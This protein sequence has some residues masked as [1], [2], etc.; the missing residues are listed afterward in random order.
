MAQAD[1]VQFSLVSIW[2]LEFN[3][4]LFLS[5][6]NVFTGWNQSPFIDL[7]CLYMVISVA[8]YRF[9]IFFT[10]SNQSHFNDFQSFFTGSNRSPFFRFTR[11]LKG[12]KSFPSSFYKGFTKSKQSPFIDLQEFYRFKPVSRLWFTTFLQSQISLFFRFTRF[13]QAII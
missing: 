10:G 5:N 11:I 8:L 13:L 2:T 4:S 6:Y 3:Q 12:Q 9:T 7:Q 1:Q